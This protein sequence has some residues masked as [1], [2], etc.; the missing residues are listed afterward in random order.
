MGSESSWAGR[1]ATDPRSSKGSRRVRTRRTA[2]PR[3]RAGR[4]DAPAH[5]GPG[6]FPRPDATDPR[7][8]GGSLLPPRQRE[9]HVPVP[10]VTYV[11]PRVP[12][13]IIAGRWHS[14]KQ[15][16][17]DGATV[18]FSSVLAAARS[19]RRWA[20]SLGWSRSRPVDPPLLHAAALHTVPAHGR[21]G[22]LRRSRCGGDRVFTAHWWPRH[23]DRGR[24]DLLS[25]GC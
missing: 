21:R 8:D 25:W 17:T 9:V 6:C 7:D 22:N 11:P 18:R 23:R 1:S 14:G 16:V 2:L 3:P 24:A 20:V 12:R 10:R 4:L 19:N 13:C 5:A 15:E